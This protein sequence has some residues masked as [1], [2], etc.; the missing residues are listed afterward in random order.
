MYSSKKNK[1]SKHRGNKKR[2]SKYNQLTKKDVPQNTL[3]SPQSSKEVK[4]QVESSSLLNTSSCSNEFIDLEHS[5]NQSKIDDNQNKIEDNQK[6]FY[7]S[8]DQPIKNKPTTRLLKKNKHEKKRENSFFSL[9]NSC[10][11]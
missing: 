4:S 8:N 5:N 2:T 11:Q 6:S 3:E 10:C 1:N 7:L 9:I